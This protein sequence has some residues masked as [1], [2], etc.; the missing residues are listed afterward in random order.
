MEKTR[1]NSKKPGT[2]AMAAIIGGA[3]LLA[4]IVVIVLICTLGKK[5]EA[6]RNIRVSEVTGTVTVNREGME[7]LAAYANMNLLSGDEIVTEAGARVALRLD[8]DKY[9]ILDEQSKLTLHATGTEEDSK[10]TLRLEYGAVF[11]DIKDKLSE[12]SGYEVV[13]PASTMSVRGTQFEVAF[14][15]GEA[16]VLTYEGAVYVAPEGAAEGR[17]VSA[18]CWISVVEAPDGTCGF[19]GEIKTITAEDVG[20]FVS[21]YLEEAGIEFEE[22]DVQT[23]PTK[24]P[25]PTEAPE[26]TPEPTDAPD[27]EPTKEPEVTAAP[28][29]EPVATEAPVPTEEPK[30]TPSPVPT[31]EPEKPTKTPVAT[32]EPKPTKEPVTPSEPGK[33]PGPAVKP[34]GHAIGYYIPLPPKNIL[35]SDKSYT[36]TYSKGELTVSTAE[37]TDHYKANVAP[38]V[39]DAATL[40]TDAAPL[41][42][43]VT[44]KQFQ[45][46][47]AKRLA[48]YGEGTTAN[49]FGWYDTG[50]NMWFDWTRYLRDATLEDGML[51]L[52]PAYTVHAP[53]YNISCVPV[54]VTVEETGEVFRLSLPEGSA[55]KLTGGAVWKENGANAETIQVQYSTISQFILSVGK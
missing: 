46:T 2:K 5:D 31:K 29:Q 15:N 32:P 19:D 54:L 49:C 1:E 11:S 55:L 35:P 10:T 7:E 47:L 21:S 12:S 42:S 28:T 6:Y 8:D 30:A 44:K 4:A 20:S 40:E 16:K 13:T 39:T 26:E 38:T 48:E 9:V 36:V 17:T 33:E 45:D 18:G 25:D 24:E 43:A 23:E 50:K 51:R 53:A 34:G 27:I 41:I 22:D 52:Y 37:S 14:R 3:V